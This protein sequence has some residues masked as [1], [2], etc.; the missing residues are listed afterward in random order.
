VTHINE[1][2]TEH[3]PDMSGSFKRIMFI[4]NPISGV[5]RNP[6]KIEHWINE[7]FGS[8][9]ENFRIAYTRGKGDA[10]V[11]AKE[12]IDQNFEMVVAIGG[13]GTINEIGRSLVQS[14]VVLGV[15]PAGS[16]NGFARNFN[17]S[18]N[19]YKALRS[20]LAPKI[21]E[22]D[23]GQ[24]NSH[25]FFNTA[26]TG[27]DAE[28]SQS[29]EHFGWR[30][31]LPYFLIGTRSYLSYQPDPITLYFDGKEMSYSPILLSIANAPQYG[32]GAI[33]A[34]AAKPDD[35]F[36]D[37][38]ILENLPVWKAAPNL[39]RLFNGTIDQIE[40]FHSFQVKEITI[41]RGR[42]G[43]IHTDGNPQWE[44]ATLKVRVLPKALKIAV[45]S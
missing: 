19:H 42:E 10:S 16:G 41:E 45:S 21:I 29:F 7:I 34:P 40:G 27:L 23:A 26:G 35:G 5:N 25:F 33:I 17:I 13:D 24:I 31:P 22:I 20:L 36:L 4:L 11:L 14:K 6:E 3:S 30:G 12:A 18:M 28:I 39:Y 15:V 8:L 38:C 32:N 2:T 43:A 1:H 37:V 9:K 44:E